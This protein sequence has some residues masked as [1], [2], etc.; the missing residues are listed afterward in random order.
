LNQ[1]GPDI[2]R[3]ALSYRALYDLTKEINSEHSLD[4]LTRWESDI[5]F[6]AIATDISR[7]PDLVG[8]PYFSSARTDA[9]DTYLALLKEFKKSANK[10]ETHEVAKSKSQ[11]YYDVA[12]FLSEIP[13]SDD[14]RGFQAATVLGTLTK[15]ADETNRSFDET[16]KQLAIDP[17]KL[18]GYVALDL[19]IARGAKPPKL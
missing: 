16:L 13:N 17:G 3:L 15:T 14:K 2:K 4:V 10:Y 1:L 8:L 18:T 5:A 19:G 9:A 11:F 12:D 6:A 7:R